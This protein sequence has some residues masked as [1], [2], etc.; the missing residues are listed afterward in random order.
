MKSSFSESVLPVSTP[1]T[2]AAMITGLTCSRD[3]STTISVALSPTS[4]EGLSSALPEKLL[5]AR[6]SDSWLSRS[7]RSG[8]TSTSM[9]SSSLPS[10]GQPMLGS[11]LGHL[12][13]ECSVPLIPCMCRR[14]ECWR[15]RVGISHLSCLATWAADGRS[16]PA[17]ARLSKPCRNQ[18][19]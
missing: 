2:M 13:A 4:I 18:G 11:Q 7:G 15:L 12:S 14:S 19:P 1:L 10:T 3:G 5:T 17:S 8:K 6:A 16:P 9:T